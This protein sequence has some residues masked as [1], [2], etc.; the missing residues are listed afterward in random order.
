MDELTERSASELS[1]DAP[2]TSLALIWVSQGEL[3]PTPLEG[4]KL[5]LGR[6]A[7]CDVR[8]VA[9][10]VSRRHAEL[11]P[12]GPLW[13]VS[14]TGSTN[15]TFLNGER[16][17]RAP[18]EPQQV[19]R[20][21]DAVAVV[22]SGA[23][24]RLQPTFE[25]IDEGLHGGARFAAGLADARSIASSPLSIVIEGETGSGKEQLARAVHRWSGRSGPFVA[26]NCAALPLHLAESE[27]F[28]HVKGAFTG[29]ERHH[30]GYLRS[31][32]GGTLFLDEVLELPLP[33]QAKLL[34]V[35]EVREV[36]AL[37][38]TRAVP[39]DVRVLAATQEP[40][41]R[42]VTAGTFRADL[43]ARL[44][45]FRVTLPPLRDRRED[46]PHLF[47]HF[48]RAVCGGTAPALAP[49]LVEALCRY[50][51]PHNVRELRNVARQ[52]AVL[53][54][55]EATLG[56]KHLP[57]DWNAP[58]GPTAAVATKTGA[59]ARRDEHDL[60]QLVLALKKHDGR[61]G[62]ACEEAGLSR[63][64]AQRLLQRYPQRDPRR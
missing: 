5:V 49:K 38:D 47:R 64:R 37:G 6:D 54:S 4:E 23:A 34:R 50:S 17:G 41:G 44:S 26:V 25:R 20:L 14:D 24:G 36:A 12:S 53:H 40:L 45:E 62:K 57:A 28:G 58:L 3:A 52:T 19:L 30:P 15:G 35:L 7:E 63:Q 59:G 46:V 43:M 60:E 21:G 8:L 2:A 22:T 16:I 27:L 48:L 51:W 42:R 33:L 29:A 1:G 39:V 11:V 56:V 9:A 13:V 10:G 61:L 32:H 18:L 31:A 55:H